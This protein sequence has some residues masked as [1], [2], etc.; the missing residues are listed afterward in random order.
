MTA[1]QIDNREAAHSESNAI[2]KIKSVVIRSPMADRVVHAGEQFA[3]DLRAITTN[4]A[5][6]ATHL[7]LMMKSKPADAETTSYE[8]LARDYPAH[9]TF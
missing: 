9:M 8:R 4:N 3:V 1:L 5:G 6:Y 7:K 2:A